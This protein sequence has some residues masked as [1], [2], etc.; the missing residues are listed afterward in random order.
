MHFRSLLFS[1][2]FFL[3]AAFAQPARYTPANGH[4]HNDYEHERP[5]LDALALDYG[6]VEADVYPVN[7]VL[8]VAHNAEDVKPERS[9]KNLYLQPLQ[10][11]LGETGSR[12]VRLLVDI[13]EDHPTALNLLIDELK[14]LQQYC[15]RP[16]KPKQLTILISGSRPKPAEY[17]N[18]PAYILFDD[19]W[20]EPHTAAQ[21]KRVGMVSLQFSRFASWKGE[22]GIAAQDKA[23]LQKIVNEVH[24]KGKPIRFWGAPDTQESWML[25]KALGADYIGADD[26]AGL[27]RLLQ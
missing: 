13:K 4:A 6:S 23:A 17:P 1:P 27:H 18:Y 22:G 26:L 16:G 15:F 9:L 10:K 14:P 2:L 11:M 12:N 24:A 7:G 8:L 20:K 25:Q 3:C 5:L 19:D 21:W